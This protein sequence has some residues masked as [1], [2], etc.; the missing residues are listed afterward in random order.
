MQTAAAAA[1]SPALE[2]EVLRL[3]LRF[4]VEVVEDFD[5]CPFARGSRLAGK[6]ARRVLG[7]DRVDAAATLDETLAALAAMEADAAEPEIGLL[8]FPRLVGA[9]PDRW[10]AF[11]ERFRKAAT[12]PGRRNVFAAAAFHPRYTVDAASAA[13]MVQAFR[14]SPDP[15]IQLVRMSTLDSVRTGSPNRTFVLDYSPAALAELEERLK[16]VP[17]A[18][19]ITADNHARVRDDVAARLERVLGD[20]HADRARSYGS[21]WDA[22]RPEK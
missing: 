10:N 15:T 4:L 16:H 6:V 7:A 11:V 3:N 1:I 20:I 12:K 22:K 2:A 21:T 13:R 18:D 5:L 19:R 9:D 8:I 14:R 17:L